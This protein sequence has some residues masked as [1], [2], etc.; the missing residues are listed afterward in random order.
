MTIINSST[1]TN[2]RNDINLYSGSG[3]LSHEGIQINNTVI[4]NE[5]KWLD[6]IF[7][8]RIPEFDARKNS[9]ENP[10]FTISN[11]PDL[12]NAKGPYADLVNKHQLGMAERLLLIVSLVPHYKPEVFYTH[13]LSRIS[14]MPIEET[15]IGGY[16]E[17]SSK[18]FIPSLQTVLFLAAGSDSIN[19]AYHYLDGVENGVLIQEQIISLKSYK[20]SEYDAIKK[21]QVIE[22]AQEYVDYLMYGRKPRLDFGKDFPATWVTT[23]LT[24]DHLILN[25]HTLL[26]IQDVMDWVA[27]REDVLSRSEGLINRSFPCLFYGPPGTGKSLTAKLIGKHYKKDVFRIDLSMIVSKYIGE[28]E[29]NLARLFDRAENKDLI[30]FF[31]EADSLFGKR[32]GISDSKDKWANLEMSYLL[33]RMEEYSGLCILATN[34]KHNLDS[35]LVR[36]F[37][38]L[39][40]FPFPKEDERAIIWQKSLPS[41]FQYPQG[42]SYEKLARYEFSGANIANIIKACCVK[43]AKKGDYFINIDDIRRFIRI[44]YAKEGRTV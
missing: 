36:R 21:Q 32:T 37:Q 5:L 13:I 17:R 6:S 1:D 35:A 40:N 38:A 12:S 24:W 27:Y 23:N 9:S 14:G 22:L 16:I 42:I 10:G 41:G 25:K 20:T 31:D 8:M 26:Q 11:I 18:Q 15:R 4:E 30:L 29:K 2:A 39:I 33:Q 19:A 28:T 34:L 43:A 7:E 44:E 3:L